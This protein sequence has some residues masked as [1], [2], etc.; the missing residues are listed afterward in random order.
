MQKMLVILSMFFCVVILVPMGIVS[1]VAFP[2]LFLPMEPK[3][4]TTPK[5]AGEWNLL[6]RS[7][8]HP[9]P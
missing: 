2:L 4:K 6:N 3:E 8:I 7:S 5:G 1:P 9:T